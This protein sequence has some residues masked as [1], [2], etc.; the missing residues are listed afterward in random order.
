MGMDRARKI[1]LE[2]FWTSEGWRRAPALDP[3]EFAIAK[4]AGVMFDPT[5]LSHAEAVERAT[6]ASARFLP[7]E[8]AI[9]FVASLSSRRLEARSALGSFAVGRELPNHSAVI[10]PGAGV[11]CGV[12]SEYLSDQMVDWNVLNFE[13]LKWGGVRHG[14]PSYIAFDLTLFERLVEHSPTDNDWSILRHLLTI[15]RSL[16][17]EARP[18]DLERALTRVLPSNKAERRVLLQI[19]GYTGILQPTD[20]PSYLEQ[21]VPAIHRVSYTEWSYPLSLWRGADGVSEEAV[22]FWFPELAN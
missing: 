15:A 14:S 22:A 7:R 16:S 8:V 12:C 4:G 13:R 21:F 5:P 18:S 19:L 3:H 10:G 9:E 1:L 20:S 17:P 11:T 6:V 2:T